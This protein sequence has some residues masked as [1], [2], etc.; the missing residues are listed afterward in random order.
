MKL[1]E[2]LILLLIFPLCLKNFS[3]GCAQFLKIQEKLA[4]IEKSF[5]QDLFISSSFEKL[6][7]ESIE[8]ES[9]LSEKKISGWREMCKS[10]LFDEDEINVACLGFFDG[11]ALFKCEWK[12]GEKTNHVF[13]F[14]SAK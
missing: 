13:Q 11:K 7:A 2:I 12:N 1:I 3:S 14:A 4:P 5:Q 10:F 9:S 8:T 6:C